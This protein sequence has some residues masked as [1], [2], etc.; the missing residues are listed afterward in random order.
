MAATLTAVVKRLALLLLLIVVIG[1]ALR[2]T[3]LLDR[4]FIFFPD[5]TLVATPG[6]LGLEFEDVSFSASNGVELHGWFVPGPGETTL[7]WFHG[8]AGN[9]SHRVNNLLELHRRLGANVFIFDYR[10]YGLSD[11][12]ISEK[13]AYLDAEAALDY[14]KS[15]TELDPDRLVLFGRSLGCAVAVEM[16]AR[17]RVHAVILESP[18]G[19]IRNMAQ[20]HYPFLPSFLVMPFLKSRFDSLAKIRDVRSPVLVLHGDRDDLIPIDVGRELFEA[21][22]GPKRFYTIEGAGHNDTYVVGGA[23]YFDEL[24]RFIDDPGGSG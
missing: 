5:P 19:S 12:T 6:D 20:R 18:F 3:G 1:T 7:V 17:H 4:H 16:A 23:R 24:K 11:G 8:N 14:L 22:N 10:G 13:G 2:V 9:I 15:R 21:A